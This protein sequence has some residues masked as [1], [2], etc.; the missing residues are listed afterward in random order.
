MSYQA[1][2][3]WPICWWRRV[4]HRPPGASALARPSSGGPE[5]WLGP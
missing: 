4:H 1:I 5:R 2:Y 3:S